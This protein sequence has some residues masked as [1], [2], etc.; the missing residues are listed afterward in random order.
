MQATVYVTGSE[1][2]IVVAT[3]RASAMQTGGIV[4]DS[5][6]FAEYVLSFDK[7]PAPV[8]EPKPKPERSR[9]TAVYPPRKQLFKTPFGRTQTRPLIKPSSYG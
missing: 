8:E 5:G 1:V 6:E 9:L 4:V 3:N 7:D 2:L